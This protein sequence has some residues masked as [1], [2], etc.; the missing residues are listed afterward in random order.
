[1]ERQLCFYVSTIPRNQFTFQVFCRL[2]SISQLTYLRKK[3]LSLKRPLH[4]QFLGF[5]FITM[6]LLPQ[7]TPSFL[8]FP[9]CFKS[10]YFFP[11]WILIVI[12]Y[13][14]WE[15]SRNNLKS[16]LLP[17]IVLTFQRFTV[18]INCSSDLKTFAYS[19]PS[20]SNFKSFFLI[21][22]KFYSH[23]KAEQFW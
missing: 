17:K 12:I 10:Q 13:W 8:T 9:A 18:W 2:K 23:S 16:I 3:L 1:M 15:T 22:W 7:K 11:I 20:A 19:R 6:Y 4:G 5:A 21:T 14:I